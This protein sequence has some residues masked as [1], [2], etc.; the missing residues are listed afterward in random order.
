LIAL[1]ACSLPGLSVAQLPSQPFLTGIW[2]GTMTVVEDK[3]QGSPMLPPFQGEQFPFRLD[4]RNTNLV[5]YF[6]TQDGWTGI[7]EGSDLRLNQEGRSA[8]VV[9]SLPAGELAETWMI[10]VARW[11]EQSITVYLSRVTSADGKNAQRPASFAAIGQMTRA[12]NG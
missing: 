12:N 6:R 8:V 10:N 2:E 9:A 3:G 11:D 5:F 7:G 1:C 4:I